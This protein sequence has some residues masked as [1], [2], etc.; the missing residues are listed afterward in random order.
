LVKAQK[1]PRGQ[2]FAVA[3]MRGK[4]AQL[5]GNG[6][7]AGPEKHWMTD[8]FSMEYWPQVQPVGHAPGA[9]NAEQVRLQPKL[10]RQ[11]LPN[12]QVQRT[13]LLQLF[14]AVPQRLVQYSVAGSGLQACWLRLWRRA[15][16]RQA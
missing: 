16:R 1:E 11:T 5:A 7:G 9:P 10:A 2:C 12:G 6:P 3:Q 8:V 4:L 15:R 14:R 13:G